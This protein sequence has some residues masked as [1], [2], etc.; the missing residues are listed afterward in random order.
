MEEFPGEGMPPI[1]MGVQPAPETFWQ[2]VLRFFRGLFGLDSAPPQTEPFM[3]G[4]MEGPIVPEKP[5]EVR[6]KG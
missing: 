3:E 1:D 4:P 6:P 2:K 5:V